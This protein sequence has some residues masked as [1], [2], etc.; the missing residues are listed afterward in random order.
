MKPQFRLFLRRRSTYYAFDTSTKRYESLN[1]KDKQ[2]ALRLV[3]ALNE[4]SKSSALNRQIAQVYWRHSDSEFPKRTWQHVMDEVAKTKQGATRDRWERAMRESPFDHV[5][6]K[7]LI[8]TSAEDFIL[9]LTTGTVSTNTF[10]RRLQ[11]FAVDMNWLPAPVILRRQWPRIVF[12]EKRGIREEEHLKI[13]EGE[14]NP[15]WRAYY[16]LLFSLFYFLFAPTRAPSVA[17]TQT[18]TA[19]NGRPR[20]ALP[21]DLSNGSHRA[22]VPWPP[23][24]GAIEIARAVCEQFAFAGPVRSS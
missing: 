16:K 7:T 1:T 15:E 23:L 6:S 8:D 10:L 14:Q 13:L 5:R 24:K 17:S 2:H 21:A 4:S 18:A 9:V 11:N 22:F 12:K 3:A 19:P 20:K